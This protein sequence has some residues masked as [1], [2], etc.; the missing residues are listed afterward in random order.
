MRDAKRINIG[1]YRQACV[2]NEAIKFRDVSRY[3]TSPSENVDSLFQYAVY[4]TKT[5]ATVY[6]DSPFPTKKQ[7]ER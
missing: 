7:P 5:I 2:V 6:S 3:V 4:Y 1:A